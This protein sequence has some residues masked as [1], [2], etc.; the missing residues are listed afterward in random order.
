MNDVAKVNIDAK[1]VRERTYGRSR[2]SS[3]AS[4]IAECVELQNGC[5]CCNASEELLEAVEKLLRVA[6]KRG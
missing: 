5:A 1:L 2:S 4:E 6:E 3:K